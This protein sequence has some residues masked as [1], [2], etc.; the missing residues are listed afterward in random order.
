MANLFRIKAAEL[1]EVPV[2]AGNTKHVIYFPDLPNLRTKQ[3]EAI[4]AYA[5]TELSISPSGGVIQSNSDFNSAVVTL[6][7]TG[8]E[9]I[10]VPL[11]ALRNLI[12]A[13]N[14]AVYGDLFT[15]NGQVIDWTKSYITLTNNIGNFAN[16]SFIFNVYYVL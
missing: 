8:G 16:K 10:V 9:Y 1:V 14:H 7:F 5:I 11:A 15:I 13:N 3:I 4:N 6:Y 12:V 2:P